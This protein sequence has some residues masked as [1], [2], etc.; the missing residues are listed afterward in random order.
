MNLLYNL[1]G[2]GA[3]AT[4]G[5]SAVVVETARPAHPDKSFGWALSVQLRAEYS[6]GKLLLTFSAAK[7]QCQAGN[8]PVL[9]T[10]RPAAADQVFWGGTQPM[11]IVLEQACRGV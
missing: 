5:E 2:L 10:A 3:R 6:A 1:H 9:S 4:P 8:G 7:L 11:N